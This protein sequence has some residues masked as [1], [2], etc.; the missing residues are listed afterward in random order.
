MKP[1]DLV[2][3]ANGAGPF[4][5]IKADVYLRSDAVGIII[6]KVRHLDDMWLVHFPRINRKPEGYPG[7]WLEVVNESR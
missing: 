1:G 3:F 7:N 5:A 2:K 6:K 4:K